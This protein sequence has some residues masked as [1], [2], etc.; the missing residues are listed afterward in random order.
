MRVEAKIYLM[1]VEQAELE[2][3]RLLVYCGIPESDIGSSG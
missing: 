1:L 3:F 2:G